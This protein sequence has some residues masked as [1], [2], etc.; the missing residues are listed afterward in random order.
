[1]WLPGEETASSDA[2]IPSGNA[3]YLCGGRPPDGQA[4]PDTCVSAML[5][6]VRSEGKGASESRSGGATDWQVSSPTQG[7]GP[8]Q[9]RGGLDLMTS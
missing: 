9:G 6:G 7:V 8:P 2:D 5:I 3:R 4:C 1:M